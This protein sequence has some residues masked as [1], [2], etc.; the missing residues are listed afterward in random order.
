MGFKPTLVFV[1]LDL[2]EVNVKLLSMNANPH[3]VFMELAPIY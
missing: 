3:L 2:L 1:K